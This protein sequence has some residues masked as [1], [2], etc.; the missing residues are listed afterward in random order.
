MTKPMPT[1]SLPNFGRRGLLKGALAGGLAAAGAGALSSCGGGG[2]GGGASTSEVTLGVYQGDEVPRK[3][4]QTMIDG[5]DK[6]ADVKIN[7]VDH[8]TFK[9]NINNYLQGNPDDVF[10][11]FAGY[12]A[13]FFAANGL[14]ADLSDIWA[15]F[16]GMPESMKNA[17]STPD[18]KQ[19]LVPSTYYAWGV[20]FRPSVWD[21]RGYAEPKTKEE[22]L[23]LCEKMKGDGLVPLAFADKGGW[24]AMGTFDMINLRVNGYDYHVSLMAGE[25][26]WDGE[27]VK[28][29]FKI[30]DEFTP[31]QQPDALGRTWQEGAQALLN[32]QAGMMTMGMFIGQQFEASNM[33][34]DLDFFI[35]P[36]FDSGIGADVVEAPIDGF[37][38]AAD[39]AN[40]EGA[41]ELL[42]YL[43]TPA[44]QEL[45]LSV[46]PS[47]IGANSETSQD[48]YSHLQKKAVEIIGQAKNISQFLDRDTRPDF[49]S[50][51]V[52]P[53]IQSYIQ[54][55]GD[56]DNILKSVEEQKKSIFA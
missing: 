13:R 44:A 17:S 56:I 24:E 15:N 52:G 38:M 31:Y 30:W 18:G 35:F 26:A 5:Y 3:A 21:A 1:M 19:I 34:E 28:N 42:T 33:M 48:G 10:T 23:T 53:A 7:F 39:P 2:G 16:Q 11:W 22:W 6:A 36:E 43:S 40:P 8:E 50:T 20:F 47:V 9:N 41:K 45:T 46:D 55:P 51:V 27:K 32:E 14:V 29:V 37:M 12:R 54:N 25:E 4:M 49:A